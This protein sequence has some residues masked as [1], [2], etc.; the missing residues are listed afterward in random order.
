[1]SLIY[2]DTMLFVYFI[3]ASPQYGERVKGIWAAMQGRGDTLCSSVFTVGEALTGSYKRGTP[4]AAAQVREFLQPPRVELIPFTM[5]VADRY[6]QIR[7]RNRVSPPD[8][9]HLASAAQAGVDLFLTNDNRLHGLVIRGIDF[10]AGIDVNL[11]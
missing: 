6:A 7:A 4:E 11:F 1:V 10:I 9:I 3:E 8:A 2:W 5:D